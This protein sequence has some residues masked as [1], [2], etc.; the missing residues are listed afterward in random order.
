[1]LPWL[2][3]RNAR[4][5][6]PPYLLPAGGSSRVAA[7]LAAEERLA[8]DPVYT[9]KAMAGLLALRAAASWRP[10]AVRP[11]RRSALA[12]PPGAAFTLTP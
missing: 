4:G 3:A 8:L 7:A 2:L 12:G 6:R 9:A 11:H 10:A 1:M 5:G